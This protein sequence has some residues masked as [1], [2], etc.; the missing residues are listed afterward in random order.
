MDKNNVGL[1]G[2]NILLSK[3]DIHYRDSV[4]FV[5]VLYANFWPYYS[6]RMKGQKKHIQSSLHET[7]LA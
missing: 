2:N 1:S 5:N 6:I 4:E 7:A 3:L